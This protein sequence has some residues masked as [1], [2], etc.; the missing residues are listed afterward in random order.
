MVDNRLW[1]LGRMIGVAAGA[2]AFALAGAS[3]ID[4]AA[5]VPEGSHELRRPPQSLPL[6]E[7]DARLAEELELAY[8]NCL[9][10][11]ALDDECYV[12]WARACSVY[13]DQ[14]QCEVLEEG[15]FAEESSGDGA[16]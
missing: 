5:T 15:I 12:R 9:L 8:D 13:F 1:S 3:A 14:F 16:C 2:A 6:T 4:A 7:G 11:G 10:S